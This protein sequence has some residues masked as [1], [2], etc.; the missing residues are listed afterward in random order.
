MKTIVVWDTCG[1]SEINFF[2]L[3]GDYKHLD[4]VRINAYT[5][6]ADEEAKQEEL[7][8]LVYDVD[9]GDLLVDMSPEFPY[10]IPESVPG[11]REGWQIIVAAFIP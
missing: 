3:D 9:T 8:N 6:D 5:E 10:H 4:R 11:Y 2:V 1:E 7:H